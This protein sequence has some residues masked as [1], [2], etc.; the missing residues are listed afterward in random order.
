MSITLNVIDGPYKGRSFT[1]TQHDTFLVGRSIRT[2]FPLPS[3]DL[4]VSRFH[5]LIEVNPPLC[6]LVDMNSHNGT[7]VNGNR[8]QSANLSAGDTIRAG[9][10]TFRV[11][12]SEEKETKE[13]EVSPPVQVEDVDPKTPPP[14]PDYIQPISAPEPVPTN[15]EP[16]RPDIPGWRLFRELGRG[17]IGTVYLAERKSDGGIFALKVVIPTSKPTDAQTG[18][19]LR[20]A[21]ILQ[22]LDH[23]NIVTFFELGE[24]EGHL[25]F[26]MDYVPGPTVLQ[27]IQEQGSIPV[28]TAVRILCQVLQALEYAH[29]QKFVHRDIKPGNIILTT[30]EGKKRTK[31]I[32]FGLARVYHASA[33]SG[34]TLEGAIGG[35]VPYM[36]PEQILDFRAVDPRADQYS[37][38]ATLYTMLTGKHVFD[39]PDEPSEALRVILEE[40]PIPIRERRS[41]LPESLAEPI[42]RAL[43]KAPENRFPS[44]VEFRQALLNFGK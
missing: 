35:T 39:F 8:V 7:Y 20:E 38:A 21:E 40:Q 37:S 26:A 15:Q 41:D 9:H 18:R 31:L 22:K 3:K 32:D 1:F 30:N 42:H 14:L 13:H 19:F 11:S 5:F 10:T 24:S 28:R 33:L 17:G 25:Y 6:R 23:P 27:A 34:L 36:P 2:H 4:R 29:A 44:V 43:D 12:F 16:L